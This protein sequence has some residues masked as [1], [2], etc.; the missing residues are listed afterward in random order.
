MI[1]QKLA[2]LIVMAGFL[3]GAWDAW[4]S[5]RND[6][7][8]IWWSAMAGAAGAILAVIVVIGFLAGISFLFS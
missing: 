5:E 4:R 7:P 8:V 1:L 3:Y 6:W 2:V